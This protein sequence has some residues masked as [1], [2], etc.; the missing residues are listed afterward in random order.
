ME[1]NFAQSPFSYL[2]PLSEFVRTWGWALKAQRKEVNPLREGLYN[3]EMSSQGST[4][5]FMTWPI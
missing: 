5:G 4:A 1:A 2:L 3:E